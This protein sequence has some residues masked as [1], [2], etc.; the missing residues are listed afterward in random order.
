M[1]MYTRVHTYTHTHIARRLKLRPPWENSNSHPDNSSGPSPGPH[2]P[3]SNHDPHSSPAPSNHGQDTNP[4]GQD[5]VS[6]TCQQPLSQSINTSDDEPKGQGEIPSPRTDATP[7]AKNT[8]PM[9]KGSAML[10]GT[11]R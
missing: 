9:E 11:K 6:V 5:H 3:H 8:R 7:S 2:R 4:K 10:A 1:M